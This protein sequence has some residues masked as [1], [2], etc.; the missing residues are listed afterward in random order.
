MTIETRVVKTRLEWDQVLALRIAVF[1]DEQNGPAD[2]EPD[3]YDP[4]ARHLIARRG[5]RVVGCARLI[6]L[7]DGH[8]KIGRVAVARDHRGTGV[9]DHL[10]RVALRILHSEGARSVTLDAQVPVIGFY[11]RFGFVAGGGEFLDGGIPHRKMVLGDLPGKR[12]TL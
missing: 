1:I 8:A 6:D 3:G 5:D 9:G 2:E 12:E 11:E 7:G 10:M 4:V